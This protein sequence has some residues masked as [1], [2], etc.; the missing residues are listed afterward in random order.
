MAG[1]LTLTRGLAAAAATAK[2]AA[3]VRFPPVRPTP[4]FIATHVAN[5]SRSDPDL[6]S[7]RPIPALVPLPRCPPANPPP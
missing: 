1:P 3:K 7:L 4:D 2:S 6:R 5:P